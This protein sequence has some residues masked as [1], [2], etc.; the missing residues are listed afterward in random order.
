[1]PVSTRMERS[2]IA[3]PG[4]RLVLG[5]LWI[6]FF[7]AY[8]DRTN[9]TIAGPALMQ[10]FGFGPA[11]FGAVLAAFTGGYAL[12]QIPGGML[13]D[14][15]GAKR[16]L[17]AALLIW[18]LFTGLTG[19]ATSLALL[20]AIRFAFGLGEGIESGAH[21]RA[22]GERFTSL[23]RS[24]ASGLF[25]TALALGPAVAAPLA[26]FL[27]VTLGWRALFVWFAVPGVIVAA[28]VWR[29]FPERAARDDL[30]NEPRAESAQSAAPPWSA[31]VAYLFFNIAFW[32]LLG[33][34]PTYLNETRHIELKALGA[35]AS[36]PYLAGFAGLLVLGA[37]GHGVF[38]R[39]RAL[40]TG[41]AYL[42]AGAG[43]FAAYRAESAGASLA[44]LSFAAFFLYGGFAPFWAVVLD[45][46]PVGLRGTIG[47]FVN[48]G[49]QIGGFCAPI[50]VGAIV[51]R[52]HSFTGGFLLMIAALVLAALSL[53]MLQRRTLVAAYG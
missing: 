8:L 36:L 20:I 24:S 12:M 7:T 38:Y 42:L 2:V 41:A 15:F 32:G 40:L 37:L 22:L 17:I 39:Q 34:M 14:R 21:F 35:A 9:V 25:H 10:H 1:M 47:G 48:F 18:S 28:I 53:T 4:K 51:Q 49:G 11:I 13:A 45:A 3:T 52:T 5:L 23:E 50:A 31:F 26:S 30:E 43:L 29:F 33:W 19:L 6:A 46:V 27:L 16:V 44:G